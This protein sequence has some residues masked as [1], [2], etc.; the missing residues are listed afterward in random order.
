MT[1]NG[2]N[3][4]WLPC[5]TTIAIRGLPHEIEQWRW[6]QAYCQSRPAASPV[7]AYCAWRLFRGVRTARACRAVRDGQVVK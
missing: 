7:E 4:P 2:S 6:M 3:S 1:T 5:H